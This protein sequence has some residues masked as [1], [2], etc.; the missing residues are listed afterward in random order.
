MLVLEG[1]RLWWIVQR[2]QAGV[3][4]EGMA[5]GLVVGQQNSRSVLTGVPMHRGVLCE[6]FMKDLPLHACAIGRLFL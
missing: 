2:C 1:L 4:A 5:C 3:L 6:A